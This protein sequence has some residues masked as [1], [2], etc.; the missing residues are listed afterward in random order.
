MGLVVK[1]CIE[2]SAIAAA[3]CERLTVCDDSHIKDTGAEDGD[4]FRLIL[5]RWMTCGNAA[6]SVQVSATTCTADVKEQIQERAGVPLEE[7]RL[8][9]RN[10]ELVGNHAGEL[11]DAESLF[12][13]RS[14]ADPRRTNLGHFRCCFPFEAVP[15]GAF[16]T[17]RKVA[18]GVHGDVL[19]CVWNCQAGGEPVAVKKI[20]NRQL[21]SI[22]YSETDE[23]SAHFNRQR[24][25][26]GDED[27]LTEIGLFR[28]L[29]KQPDLPAVI[30]RL[31]GVFDG[32]DGFTWLVT[33][34]AEGGELFEAVASGH[35][36]DKKLQRY[37]L[38]LLQAVDYLHRLQ[39]GHRD[40]SLEN[41][42]LKKDTVRLMDFGMAVKSH[43][44]SGTPLRFFRAVGKD[45]YRAPE[46]YVPSSPQITVVAPKDCGPGDIA[47]VRVGNS[48]LCEVRFESDTSP[49]RFCAAEPWGYA[50]HPS[51]IF[52]A[53]ICL[54]IMSF[55][56]PPWARALLS[57]NWFSFAHGC[58]DN[59]GLESLLSQF[60]LPLPCEEVMELMKGM[61]HVDPSK[62]PLAA[63]C[64]ATPWFSKLAEVSS[65]VHTS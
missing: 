8:F 11:F 12:L 18:A 35:V 31:H 52:A 65:C 63:E 58:E 55:K 47:F 2:E 23:R 34:F 51:D 6:C 44:V 54:F 38:E 15:Y 43:S 32:G 41:I 21:E 22:K 49:G 3:D 24:N 28:F 45:F 48:H 60:K 19:E 7:Q 1:S 40:I 39:V 10:R 42:L 13:V 53:G 64:L 20:S 4:E 14:L 17:V 56:C 62:R 50:V 16:T 33:E 36:T 37:T 59:K 27:S 57:D 26:P 5:V 25:A 29:A 61:L 46:C 30:L 9:V